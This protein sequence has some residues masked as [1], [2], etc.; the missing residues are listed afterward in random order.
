MSVGH[1]PDQPQ[2]MG[3]MQKA[4]LTA[5]EKRDAQRRIAGG[6]GVEMAPDTGSSEAGTVM[7]WVTPVRTGGE[8]R[9]NKTHRYLLLFGPIQPAI[10]TCVPPSVTCIVM[11]H[12]PGKQSDVKARSFGPCGHRRALQRVTGA[13]APASQ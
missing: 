12:R 9:V 7:P 11:G 3:D 2:H 4:N 5:E 13:T 8:G 6:L 1:S 10:F